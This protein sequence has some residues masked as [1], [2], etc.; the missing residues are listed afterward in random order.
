MQ[1]VS[2]AEIPHTVLNALCGCRAAENSVRLAVLIHNPE[3]RIFYGGSFRTGTVHVTVHGRCVIVPT[4][5]CKL[6]SK[7]SSRD[8]RIT[9]R[10]RRR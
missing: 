4:E 7:Y 5:C 9:A 3:E 8:T 2:H 10:R 6:M 1:M